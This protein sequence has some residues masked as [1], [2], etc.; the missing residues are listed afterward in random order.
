MNTYLLDGS[1]FQIE[2][3]N[4]EGIHSLP[5]V[6]YEFLP[7]GENVV[8]NGT[9]WVVAKA[10]KLKVKNGELESSGGN[11]SGLKLSY[12]MKDSTFK[13]SF[14]VYSLVGGKLKKQKFTVTGIVMNGHGYGTAVLTKSALCLPVMIAPLV[15]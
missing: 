11:L 3:T 6:L 8:Q 10:G 5:G 9:K 13:G 7:N 12:K 15:D 14:T 4:S 2:E 1:S